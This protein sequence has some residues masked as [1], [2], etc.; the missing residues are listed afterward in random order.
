RPAHEHVGHYLLDGRR[1]KL[2]AAIG[3]R[4]TWSERLRRPILTNPV[5]FYLGGLALVVA[6]LC[7]ASVSLLGRSLA[8]PWLGAALLLLFAI[9]AS[10]LALSVLNA[11]VIFV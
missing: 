4:P 1:Q 10:E 6:A 11:L 2:E 7:A 3:Y 8:N 5:G 9:P